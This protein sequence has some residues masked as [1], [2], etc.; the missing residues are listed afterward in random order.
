[1]AQACVFTNNIIVIPELASLKLACTSQSQA[2]IEASVNCL[3]FSID[4]LLNVNKFVLLYS[5]CKQKGLF[6]D[7]HYSSM[8]CRLT[9]IAILQIVQ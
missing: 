3:T 1:M 7:M 8:S 5:H 2:L 4:L 9:G 6:H